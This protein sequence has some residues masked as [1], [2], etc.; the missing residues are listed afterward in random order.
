MWLNGGF[1][2]DEANTQRQIAYSLLNYHVGLKH[3]SVF[4][5]VW[6]KNAFDRR[7]I[8]IAFA[9]PRLVP[10]GFVG[11]MGPPRRVGLRVGFTF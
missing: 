9:Y 6:V 4:G 3:Q 5:E 1:E 10:S 7:Y 11:E 8:P 2:Y